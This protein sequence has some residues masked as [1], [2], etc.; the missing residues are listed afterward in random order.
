[1][2]ISYKN[3]DKKL[4]YKKYSLAIRKLLKNHKSKIIFSPVDL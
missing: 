3:N 4:N 1:M 2:G